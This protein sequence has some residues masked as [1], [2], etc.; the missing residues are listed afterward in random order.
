[1]AVSAICHGL[2]DYEARPAQATKPR[3]GQLDSQN[4]RLRNVAHLATSVPGLMTA[5]AG[6]HHARLYCKP[7]SY[8]AWLMKKARSFQYCPVNLRG[9]GEKANSGAAF[10]VTSGVSDL[11]RK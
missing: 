6:A 8:I 10:R 1:M 9:I 7:L 4:G 5:Q 3:R 11:N 2:S